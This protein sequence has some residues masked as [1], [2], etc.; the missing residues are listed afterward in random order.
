MLGEFSD[1]LLLYC[2]YCPEGRDVLCKVGFVI[3]KGQVILQMNSLDLV[4]IDDDVD[5][6]D[7]DDDDGDDDDDE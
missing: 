2:E 3:V 6:V 5:D 4:M 7:D 1:K